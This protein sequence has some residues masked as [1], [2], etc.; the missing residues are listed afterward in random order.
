MYK[1]C[2]SRDMNLFLKVN[3]LLRVPEIKLSNIINNI[4]YK[5]LYYA[6]VIYKYHPT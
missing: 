1:I 6:I 3:Q 4:C 5:V 2:P